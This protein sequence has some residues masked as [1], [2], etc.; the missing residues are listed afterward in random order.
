[1]RH[2]VAFDLDEQAPRLLFD[3]VTDQQ[4]KR[5]LIESPAAANVL[6]RLRV[7]LSEA[8]LPLRAVGARGI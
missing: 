1:M 5:N 4:E 3:L 6:D 7:Q 8:L 2:K